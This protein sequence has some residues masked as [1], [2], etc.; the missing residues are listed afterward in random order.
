MPVA[1]AGVA[2]PSGADALC[3]VTPGEGLVVGEGEVGR[4]QGSPVGMDDRQAQAI[5]FPVADRAL[6]VDADPYRGI[7]RGAAVV[8]VPD[9]CADGE[10]RL[11][12]GEELRGVQRQVNL[13][14]MVSGGQEPGWCSCSSAARWSW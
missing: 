4:V 10:G 13:Q 5:V 2:V 6:E 8:G 7:G 9:D 3:G 14:V 12:F 1:D 11:E